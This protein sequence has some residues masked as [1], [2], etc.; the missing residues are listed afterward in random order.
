M[1][2]EYDVLRPYL[3]N[4]QSDDVQLFYMCHH[5]VSAELA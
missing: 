1:C 3:D 4:I 2:C 5:S